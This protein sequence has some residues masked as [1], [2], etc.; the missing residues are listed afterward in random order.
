MGHL[1][2]LFRLL[3]LA[4]RCVEVAHLQ[5]VRNALVTL[6][7]EGGRRSLL[8]KHLA[9]LLLRL[10]ILNHHCLSCTEIV[11][12]AIARPHNSRVV[13]LISFVLHQMH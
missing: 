11:H 12:S 13:V 7:S 3:V 6:P 9:I 5:V 4:C 1:N 8:V 10:I 2:L